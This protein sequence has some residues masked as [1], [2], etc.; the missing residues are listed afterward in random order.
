M[1]RDLADLLRFDVTSASGPRAVELRIPVMEGVHPLILEKSARDAAG[2][3]ATL[4]FLALRFV[5]TVDG[6]ALDLHAADELGGD[7]AFMRDL[8][9]R[10]R[11]MLQTLCEQGA[12]FALCPACGMWEAELDFTAL[13]LTIASPLPG[14]FEGPFLAFPSLASPDGAA[15]RPRIAR[16]ARIRFG[17]PSARLGIPGPLSGGVLKDVPF[18][19]VPQT[20]EEGDEP[21]ASR[22]GPGWLALE[23][24]ARAVDPSLSPEAAEALPAIDFFFLDLLHY[25]V[26][27]APVN[28]DTAGK[29]R[30]PRCGAEFLP[31]RG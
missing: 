24:L 9:V 22:T 13:A 14:V 12:V 7:A 21:D 6:R 18:E 11:T 16:A 1:S 10:I 19:R 8:L 29:V 27:R 23:R 31:V 2:L 25:V 5:S 30:C 3:A 28:S 17:L 20:A 4:P 15:A 26:Y